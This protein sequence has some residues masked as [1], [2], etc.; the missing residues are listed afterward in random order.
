MC[1]GYGKAVVR[2]HLLREAADSRIHRC[3]PKDE[4]EHDA[5]V[6]LKRS[7]LFAGGE[8]R[9]AQRGAQRA[10]TGVRADAHKR[11]Q[12]ALGLAA[13]LRFRGRQRG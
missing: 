3:L 8:P 12:V 4:A 10:A 7:Q 1:A 11:K 6:A 2:S 5:L 9:G 13:Q